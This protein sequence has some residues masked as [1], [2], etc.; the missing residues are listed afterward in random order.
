MFAQLTVTDKDV[1]RLNKK[2]GIKP[3]R[4]LPKPPTP[5]KPWVP[6]VT[7]KRAKACRLIASLTP[8]MGRMKAIRHVSSTLP[9]GNSPST[10]KL[11]YSLWL[12][13]LT[14]E[15]RELVPAYNT[16]RPPSTAP[17]HV[18]LPKY[19]PVCEL[20]YELIAAHAY[21]RTQAAMQAQATLHTTFNM[22]TLLG[23]YYRWLNS[24]H[25]PSQNIRNR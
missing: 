7:P 2:L 10:M 25:L 13:T 6:V 14:P 15:E 21:S 20:M 18:K 5:P 4:Q 3:K 12:R 16:G 19:N 17:F 23:A 24:N 1:K 8:A 22:N 11:V 9:K